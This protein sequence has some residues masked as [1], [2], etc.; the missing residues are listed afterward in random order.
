M[1]SILK[2]AVTGKGKSRGAVWC[3]VV[4][5]FLVAVAGCERLE[6]VDTGGVKPPDNEVLML[7]VDYTTNAFKGGKELWFSEK[8]ETFTITN[9]YKSPGDFGHLKLFYEE[10]NELLFFGT[11]HWMGCGKMIFS[12]DLLD[13]NQFQLVTTYDIKYPKNGFENVFNP[14]NQSFDYESIWNSVQALV[15][16]REYLDANPEQVV[17]MF[18]YTPSVGVGNPADWYWVI[19]LTK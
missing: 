14:G 19:F 17:K 9:E 11:I 1:K 6:P 4:L 18:L 8:S 12:Q 10:L 3:G 15:K 2:N 13:A 5:G 7:T 16:A